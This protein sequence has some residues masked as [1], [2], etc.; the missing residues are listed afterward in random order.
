M[1]KHVLHTLY[2]AQYRYAGRDRFDITVKGQDGMG[3][4]FAPTW[5]MV[6]D[7]KNGVITDQQYIDQYIPILKSIPVH[8]LDWFL[9]SPERTLVCFC[10][11]TAFCHR[12][13]LVN[14]L[15]QIFGDRIRYG[16]FKSTIV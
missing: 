16:G 10:K 12:N 7:H 14:Y 2:T 13:I 6:S 15:I 5:N 11:E 9:S 8:V 1:T 4:H 3:K